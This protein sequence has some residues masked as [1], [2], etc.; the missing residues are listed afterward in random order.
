MRGFKIDLS[1]AWKQAERKLAKLAFLDLQELHEELGEYMIAET[2]RRFR[3][4]IE[5]GGAKWPKLKSA[6]IKRGADGR[7]VEGSGKKNNR[8]PLLKTGRLRNS[9]TYRATSDKVEVGT[10]V[11]YAA[12]H[13]FGYRKGKRVL[14]P[15]R[16]YL[17]VNERNVREMKEIIMER[18]KGL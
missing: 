8:K 14:T 15:R 11:V 16:Q 1:G 6:G 3:E 12:R 7:F 2:R 18:L 9:V 5:P 10:N 13:N 17:G 4:G